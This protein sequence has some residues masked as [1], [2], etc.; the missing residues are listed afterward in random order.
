[1]SIL[2]DITNSI[3]GLSPV[4]AGWLS[5]VGGTPVIV[6]GSP[7]AIAAQTAAIAAQNQALTQQALLQQQ[8][9]LAGLLNNPTVVIFGLLAIFL[10]FFLLL[11]K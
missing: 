11:R 9:T 8:P 7:Q 1:M 3:E 4:A 2:D 10:I 6:P 5:A